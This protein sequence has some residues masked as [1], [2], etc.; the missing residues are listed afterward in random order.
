VSKKDEIIDALV[1]DKP[2]EDEERRKLLHFGARF[3]ITLCQFC[4]LILMLFLLFYRMVPEGSRDLIS[5][6]TG[7]LVIS[8]KDAVQYWFNTHSQDNKL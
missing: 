5:A 8:Q 3:L 7:M 6:I 2:V 4:L 1:P